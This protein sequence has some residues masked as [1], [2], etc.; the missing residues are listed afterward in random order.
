[1]A[2]VFY[3]VDAVGLAD[4][5]TWANAYTDAVTAWAALLAND[6][7]AIAVTSMETLASNSTSLIAP[8]GVLVI[9]ST[10]S[11][12]DTITYQKSTIDNIETPNATGGDINLDMNEGFIEG[13]GLWA[14]RRI[15][16]T[17]TIT[18]NCSLKFNAAISNGALSLNR[19]NTL[20]Y[21]DIS[22]LSASAG[23]T[24]ISTS[25]RTSTKIQGGSLSSSSAS[26]SQNAVVTSR[27]G[28]LIVDSLNCSAFS[29]GSLVISGGQNAAAKITRCNLNAATVDL[30]EGAQTFINEEIDISACDSANSV[31]RQYIK[32]QFGELFSETGVVLDSTNPSSVITSNK[33]VSSAL[34][35][36]FFVPLR[37]SIVQGWADFSTTKT[38]SIEFCQDGTTTPLTDA[39]IWIEI[40]YP[41]DTASDYLVDTD[42]AT[43]NQTSANQTSSTA[44]WTGLSGTNLKQKCSI[45]TTQ[46]G[47]AGP[48]QVFICVAKPSTTVYVNP[49][50]DIS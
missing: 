10:V 44:A 4:G 7:L 34:V 29:G 40:Q 9:T 16:L 28:K 42:R 24:L 14:G 1:M 25:L 48:Y 2:N 45:T 23:G 37:I 12:V 27:E 30:F 35:K 13:L 47:K 41:D 3:D 6:I 20:N 18:S 39:E 21:C 50:A 46:T 43:D 49:K 8:T 22:S 31:N 5:T 19:A 11:G 15:T 26:I 38:I 33:I 36:E 17:D 32:T